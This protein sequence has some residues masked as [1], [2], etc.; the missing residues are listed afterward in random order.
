MSDQQK[1][2]VNTAIN[3]P[4]NIIEKVLEYIVFLGYDVNVLK[5]PGHLII[6]DKDDLVKKLEE[7]MS[8]TEEISFEDVIKIMDEKIS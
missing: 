4:D 6:K 5:A 8:D 2:L 7:G 1:L 3:L